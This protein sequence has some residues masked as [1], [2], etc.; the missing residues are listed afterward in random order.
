[1]RYFLLFFAL[2]GAAIAHDTALDATKVSR[3]GLTGAQARYVLKLVLEHEGYDLNKRGMDIDGPFKVD[4]AIASQRGYWEFGLTFDAPG[5]AA[6]EVLGRFAVSRL[7]ADV[8]ETNLCRRYDFPALSQ[9]QTMVMRKTGKTR[10]D[11]I[12]ARRGLGCTNE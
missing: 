4:P 10:A 12:A 8:W 1:M 5:Y 6:T 3:H 2:F 7:T 9:L 11:E